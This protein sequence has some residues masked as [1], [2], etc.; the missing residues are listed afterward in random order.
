MLTKTHKR[1]IECN[2]TLKQLYRRM[3]TREGKSRETL[4]RYLE[5][6]LSFT[7]F[8]EAESPDEAFSKLLACE[9]ITEKVDEYIDWL[10]GEGFKPINIK[11]H[12]F[13]VKKW[14]IANRVKVDWKYISRPKV[15]SQI[16]DRI[17]SKRELRIILSNKISLR[18]KAFFLV[19][20]SSGLRIGTLASLKVKD[21]EPIHELGK[22]MVEGGEGRKLAKGKFYFTFITPEAR[23]ALEQYLAT[24]GNLSP[25]DYLF[26]KA[27]GQP[28]SMYAANLSR[29][30][31]NLIRRSGLARK[32]ENHSFYELHAHT[33]RK[34]FQTN[35]KLAGCRADFVD[36]WMGHHPTRQDQYL[37]DAYFRSP[38]EQHVAEYRKA[39]PHLTVFQ[40]KVEVGLSREE[41][42]ALKALLRR[43]ME[44]EIKSLL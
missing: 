11:A 3:I 42:E 44:G 12:F 27:S 7:R 24:R 26:T 21:Y 25:E 10:I 32:I 16:R 43:M 30:W 4:R 17:P 5:G 14:L 28:I 18:D 23:E 31:R 37:N 15:A 20:L 22:I 1:L 13:G 6:V 9:D 29:Q 39:V 41:V 40:A 36:F 2:K 8:M 19:A 35:C 38:M 33:L 34:F